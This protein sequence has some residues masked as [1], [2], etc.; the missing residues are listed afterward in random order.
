ME[1]PATTVVLGRQLDLVLGS[2]SDPGRFLLPASQS[3]SPAMG[4]RR[5]LLAPHRHSAGRLVDRRK[6]DSAVVAF[7]EPDAQRPGGRRS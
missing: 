4:P 7:Q 5:P 1:A 2:R 3:R 6:G